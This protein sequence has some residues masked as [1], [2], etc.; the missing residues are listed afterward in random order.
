MNEAAKE[1]DVKMMRKALSKGANPNQA[2]EHGAT[3]LHYASHYGQ[4]E[5]VRLLVESGANI[6]VADSN[7]WRPIHSAA[8]RGRLVRTTTL[9]ALPLP[10]L[11]W[12]RLRKLFVRSM[13]LH[14]SLACGAYKPIVVLCDNPCVLLRCSRRKWRSF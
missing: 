4:L 11:W 12:T 1:G 5:I 6:D 2:D 3:A 9:F 14:T 10:P 7:A 8:R 13:F